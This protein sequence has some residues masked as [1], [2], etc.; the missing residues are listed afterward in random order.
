[1]MDR[2]IIC[3]GGR[4]GSR[5]A[6]LFQKSKVDYVV[7]ERDMKVFQSLK[8]LGH[9]VVRGDALQEESLI[10]AGVKDAKWVIATLR[11]DA[12]NLYI[13]FKA[14]ELNPAV[15]TA[16]RVGDEESLES[17]Y[18]AGVDLIVMPE[19]VSGTHLAKTILQTD[20]IES[21][22]NVI[23]NIYRGGSDDKSKS[24]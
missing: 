6:A 23:R 9:P 17:F 14:K 5:I 21:V 2:H 22:E 15:K 24:A 8:E 20:K 12:D 7:V 19:I 13:V 18:K 1:M 16:V 3:G 4:L 10:R 11:S